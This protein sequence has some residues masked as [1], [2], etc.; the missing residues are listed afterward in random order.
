MVFI[1]YG[2]HVFAVVPHKIMPL[3]DSITVGYGATNQFTTVGGLG[4]RMYIENSLLDSGILYDFIGSS[5]PKGGNLRNILS[6]GQI[7]PMFDQDNN[8]FSGRGVD[9]FLENISVYLQQN[10]NPEYVL[11]LLGV[12]D[13]AIPIS[14]LA[15]KYNQ[16]WDKILQESPTS[17]IIVSAISPN[18]YYPSFQSDFNQ[19]LQTEVTKRI[20]SKQP[21]SYVNP[22][23]TVDEMYDMGHPNDTGHAKIG[24]TFSKEL[25]RLIPI[26][27]TS[28]PI[29]VP[30]PT[31]TVIVKKGDAN[32]DG[33]ING[34]DYV[35]W[36]NHYGIATN[37]GASVGDF[38]G[39]GS[40][41]GVDYV[42]WL[43]NYGR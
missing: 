32:A 43:I 34:L 35:I 33:Y 22:Q 4:Y 37:S 28:T 6:D 21:F 12:N 40:V 30:T 27:P 41:N 1:P 16:L 15:V 19:M 13:A 9:Y 24:N 18:K 39:D 5:E 7:G 17:Y 2:P 42:T 11:F 23:V 26:P 20:V 10:P 29:S 31:D 8:G 38:N 25:L 14:Q 3:G 36:L